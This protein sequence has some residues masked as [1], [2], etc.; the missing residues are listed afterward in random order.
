MDSAIRCKQLVDARVD[1]VNR[2]LLHVIS[3]GWKMDGRILLASSHWHICIH[4]TNTQTTTRC[5]RKEQRE[6][7]RKWSKVFLW[8]H[9]S[10]WVVSDTTIFIFILSNCVQES[11]GYDYIIYKIKVNLHFYEPIHDFTPR[12]WGWYLRLTREICD[13]SFRLWHRQPKGRMVQVPY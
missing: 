6:T 10:L 7:T 1:R 2:L 9:F 8:L 11:N 13:R 4:T 3:R 5:R 12:D